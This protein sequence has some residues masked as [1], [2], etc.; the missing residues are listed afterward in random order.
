MT[1]RNH[2]NTDL[3]H[4]LPPELAS[5]DVSLDELARAERDATPDTLADRALLR[6]QSIITDAER[7]EPRARASMIE[8][9]PMRFARIAAAILIAGAA[10]TV[11]LLTLPSSAPTQTANVDDERLNAIAVSFDEWLMTE[12]DLAY[13]DVDESISALRDDLRT[14]ESSEPDALDPSD[15]ELVL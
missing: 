13:D 12:S 7:R 2:H 4:D 5:L 9:K 11:A 3:P 8:R 14:L 10:G 6:T 15:E 1:D